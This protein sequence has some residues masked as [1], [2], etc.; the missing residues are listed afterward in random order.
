[1]S[2][3]QR[4]FTPIQ[5][6]PAKEKDS[7]LNL[8][9]STLSA[10]AHEPLPK[11]GNHWSIYLSTSDTDYIRLD[12]TPSYTVPATVN[13]G[14]SKGTLIVSRVDDLRLDTATKVVPLDVRGGLKVIDFVD[15][16]VKEKRYLYEFN[17]AGQGCRFWVHHQIG[18]FWDEGLIVDSGQVEE[19]RRAI[20][21][22]YPEM[23]E[24]GLVVGEYY[25]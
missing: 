13:P 17:D 7:I 19:A 20:L 16:L 15:L 1:M 24:Y 14:G 9:I 23:V 11:G 5:Y 8:P 4:P 21:V 25:S 6:I 22:M 18:L 10:V 12:M 2:T 3:Q